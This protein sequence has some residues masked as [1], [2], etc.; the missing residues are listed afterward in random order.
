MLTWDTTQE[1]KSN[2]FNLSSL[3]RSIHPDCFNKKKSS[4]Y[5]HWSLNNLIER[6]PNNWILGD[7]FCDLFFWTLSS[8]RL[9]LH[10][11]SQSRRP[12][13]FAYRTVAV[14]GW[15]PQKKNR[16]SIRIESND[17]SRPHTTCQNPFQKTSPDRSERERAARRARK[18]GVDVWVTHGDSRLS[19]YEIKKSWKEF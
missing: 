14:V 12:F 1:L 2:I 11:K 10:S 5:I 16:Y 3:S 8:S 6:P 18:V 9:E 17:C 15:S 4:L 7:D 13:F 19:D